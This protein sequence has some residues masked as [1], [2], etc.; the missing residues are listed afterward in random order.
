M[1]RRV[2]ARLSALTRGRQ[3]GW[4]EELNSGEPELFRVGELLAQS[5]RQ[6]GKSER[7]EIASMDVG[8][9]CEEEVLAACVVPVL[10]RGAHHPDP[11]GHRLV[12]GARAR[13]HRACVLADEHARGA[14]SL[15]PVAAMGE[16]PAAEERVVGEKLLAVV[17]GAG[18]EVELDEQVERE[19]DRVDPELEREVGLDLAEGLQL[20]VDDR[21]AVRYGDLVER[22]G[23]A[24]LAGPDLW[25]RVAAGGVARCP[26]AVCR[27]R[28]DGVVEGDRPSGGMQVVCEPSGAGL[29]DLAPLAPG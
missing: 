23:M 26:P 13:E 19:L 8:L 15:L 9:D 20:D 3:D 5:G 4:R 12:G 7:A 21:L 29:V 27:E 16:R 14:G 22:N 1:A 24:A 18:G 28:A 6:R 10:C 25:D 17:G 11:A 2:E